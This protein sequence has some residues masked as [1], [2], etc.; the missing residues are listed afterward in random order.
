MRLA[1]HLLL[2]LL[3]APFGLQSQVNPDCDPFTLQAVDDTY[4][5][6]QANLASFSENVTDNDAINADYFL[7]MDVPPCF[8]Q[9]DQNPGQIVTSDP[10]PT[11]EIAAAPSPSLHAVRRRS[12]LHGLVRSL[13]AAPQSDC[14][15]IEL[16]PGGGDGNGDGTVDDPDQPSVDVPCVHVCE[17]GSPPPRPLLRPE[18]HDGSSPAAR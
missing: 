12:F 8:A 18:H 14:S 3:W 10:E 7:S 9:S 4:F 15:V 16:Q 17:D 1:I 2:A 6:D 11:E 5:V 13:D